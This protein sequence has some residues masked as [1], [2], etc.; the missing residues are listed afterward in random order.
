MRAGKSHPIDLHIDWN[1]MKIQKLEI[2]LFDRIY[3][4]AGCDFPDVMK[5]L[6]YS[7]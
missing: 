7:L 6:L 2:L 1:Y 3:V 5:P 4:L